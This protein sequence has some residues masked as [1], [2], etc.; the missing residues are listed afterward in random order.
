MK[1][2]TI[3]PVHDFSGDGW[4]GN[5]YFCDRSDPNLVVRSNINNIKRFNPNAKILFHVNAGFESF[6]I[7]GI[8]QIEDVYINPKRFSVTHG[9]S[10]LGSIISS[11]Q[12]AIDNNI[13]F[14]YITI[15]HSGEMFVKEGMCD[16]IKN[17]EFSSWYPPGRPKN[18]AGWQPYESVVSL[19]G[20]LYDLFC[21][22]VN[23]LDQDKLSAGFIEGSF[24]RKDLVIKIVNWFKDHFDINTL[25]NLDFVAEELLIP[26]ISYYLSETKSPATSCNVILL[27]N[28]HNPQTDMIQ[29]NR[30]RNN[31]PILAWTP[32]QFGGDDLID[33]THIYSLKRINRIIT[34]PVRQQILNL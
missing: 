5:A 4:D 22:L 2:L 17:H 12:Y 19:Y 20:R 6:D 32:N 23:P 34:D 14:D 29:V 33:S 26:T 24:F 30:I 9:K 18:L 25:N 15:T 1:L 8:S 13:D 3:C 7:D 10:Q 31:Q 11:M 16:Y 21:D 27:N 28:G